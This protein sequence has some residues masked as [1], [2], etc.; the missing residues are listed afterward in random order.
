MASSQHLGQES[1]DIRLS[2]VWKAMQIL[3]QEIVNVILPLS[4]YSFAYQEKKKSC[5]YFTVYL[6]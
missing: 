1:K 6:G 4:A 2:C 5:K 3:G